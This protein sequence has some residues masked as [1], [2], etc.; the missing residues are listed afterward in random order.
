MAEGLA[1]EGS[2][3]AAL[4]PSVPIERLVY[5]GP[6]EAA[7]GVASGAWT[8]ETVGEV[9]VRQSWELGA[10]TAL[11][12]PGRRLSF[13][14]LAAE[15]QA[16]AEHLLSIGLRPADRVLLQV[17]TGCDAAVWILAA[18]RAGIVP[19]CAVPQYRDYEMAA[20]GRLS[21]ARAHVVE[22][23]A[24]PNFDLLELACRLRE[25]NPALEHLLTIGAAPDSEKPSPMLPRL[26]T[27]DVAA[28][29]LSGGTTGV[30]KIIP[31]FHGEYMGYAAAW[32]ARL[33]LTRSDVLLWSLPIAHNAGMICFL[34]PALWSG[35]TLVLMPRFETS[36]FLETIERERVTVT[37]SI[38]PIAPKLLDVKDPSQ[39]DLSSVRLFLTLNRAAEIEQ[40]LGVAAM[41]I[42]GITEGLLMASPPV[43]GPELRHTTVG[44][45]VSP[46]DEVEVHEPGTDL[47][48][49]DGEIGELC[50]RGPSRL[51]GYFN[52][53]DATRSA[54][55]SSGFFKTG[56]LVRVVAREGQR[57]FAFEGRAKDNID[58]GGEKFGTAEIEAMLSGHPQIGEV[59]VVGMPDRYL[60]ERVCAFVIPRSPADVPT[61]DDLSGYLLE[62]GVAKFKLPERVV[63]LSEMPV[64][65]VGKLDR[66][67]LKRRIAEIID[68]DAAEA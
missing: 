49:A 68:A 6:D 25:D 27:L 24:S 12:D 28:F 44:S 46:G 37:G 60:G 9:I 31:R 17:G 58:R 22:P 38:G 20:L 67:A 2:K 41:N 62:R 26:N 53:A 42:F 3:G 23:A 34:L 21:G 1:G 64:T 30:P 61:T 18:F 52:D 66:P 39:F 51:R 8:S 40:H 35:A 57:Q 48:V 10:E 16:V 4:E 54:L 7:C 45:P 15:T 56:D 11:V 50:F 65:S 14:E 29:Q 13:S 5:P 63:Q 36:E 47:V 55:T 43:V 59:C 19:V 33:Q 32:A